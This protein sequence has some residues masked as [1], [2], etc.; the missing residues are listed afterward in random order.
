M[1]DIERRSRNFS[2]RFL[3]TAV[4]VDDEAH[5]NQV[6]SDVP[7]ERVVAPG[8]NLRSSSDKA[9]ISS[10]SPDDH[11]LNAR[12]IMDSFSAEGQICGVLAPTQTESEALKQA[13]IVVLDWLMRDSTPEYTLSLLRKL[14]TEDQERNSL[15][16][17]AIYTGEARLDDIYQTVFGELEDN[18]LGPIEDGSSY[19]IPYRHGQIVLYA[20]SGV[21]LPKPLQARSV[22]EKELPSRLV[23]D[24]ASMTEGLL[25]RIALTALTAVREGEH[26]ILDRFCAELDPAFVAHMCC[27]PDTEDAERQIV[28]HVAEELRG[29]VDE[30]VATQSPA[31]VTAVE[32]WIQRKGDASAIF[33][34][35][36]RKLDVQETVELVRK[37]LKASNNLKNNEFKHLS[38]GFSDR[39]AFDLDE[40]LAWIMSF[41]TVYN[42]PAPILWLGSVVAMM[43]KDGGAEHL[44][45]MSP[46]V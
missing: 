27:L 34:F 29:L 38:L 8:R 37:G 40:R 39:N 20:K 17:V 45:C 10:S 46:P 16:L 7:K 18:T 26:K 13:D 4:V 31:G 3:R 44:I 2:K 19:S 42:A 24:F 32:H 22:A 35:G 41:R 6:A 12:T 30:A 28:A 14:L 9:R 43:N 33:E 23:N 11:A 5:M 25:P 21:N 1:E 15:R 36:E